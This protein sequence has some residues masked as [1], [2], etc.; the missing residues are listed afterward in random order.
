MREPVSIAKLSNPFPLID[1]VLRYRTRLG[2]PSL[3]IFGVGFSR[4]GGCYYPL[5]RLLVFSQRF[6][7]QRTHDRLQVVPGFV[8]EGTRIRSPA[9]ARCRTTT[10]WMKW[11][12]SP[13]TLGPESPKGNTY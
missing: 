5:V 1:E 8:N 4:F 3:A 7:V 6:F 9:Q 11:N 13:S 10:A 12:C 2:R